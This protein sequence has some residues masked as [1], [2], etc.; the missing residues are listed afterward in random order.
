[1][2]DPG[3]EGDGHG[4]DDPPRLEHVAGKSRADDVEEDQEEEDAAKP[5]RHCGPDGKREA[6]KNHERE[7]DHDQDHAGSACDAV[8]G[9]E[10]IGD[11][12]A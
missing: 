5:A 4:A 1:M 2:D 6:R 7:R 10:K 3:D 8:A 11:G 9:P 12:S